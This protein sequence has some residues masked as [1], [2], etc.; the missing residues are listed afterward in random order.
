MHGTI[1]GVLRGGASSEHEVSL[2]SGQAI[3]NNLPKERFTGRDIYIDKQGVWHDRGRPTTPD[4]VLS[5]VD[6]VIAPLH[7]RYGENGDIQRLLEQF[8]VP[9]AGAD[10]FHSYLA[11]HKVLA[12]E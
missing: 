8:G 12:K 11:M 6:V 4:R 9:Y 7:G 3:L 10:S 2:K 1:V 5:S